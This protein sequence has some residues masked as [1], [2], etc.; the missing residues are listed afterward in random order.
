MK[1]SMET[2][3]GTVRPG[4]VIRIVRMD[5]KT[6]PSRAFPDGTDHQARACNGKTGTVELIDDTGQIHGT[7]SGLA[8][9]PERD[10]FEIVSHP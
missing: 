8:V 5:D 7:W 6:T 9:Q 1:T 2:P 10:E 4:T 3:A